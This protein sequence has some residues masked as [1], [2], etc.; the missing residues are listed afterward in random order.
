MATITESPDANGTA[1][2]IV[3]R[4][5]PFATIFEWVWKGGAAII[6]VGGGALAAYKHF[7]TEEEV[8]KL[9]CQMA[10]QNKINSAMTEASGQ[11]RS[12]LGVLKNQLVAPAN[13]DGQRRSLEAN[14]K[15]AIDG[16]D[17]ALKD[18][19]NTKAIILNGAYVGGTFKCNI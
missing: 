6:L 9:Q 16:V 1:A 17:K 4:G 13:N 19:D 12:A 18:A 11:I 14:L 5:S 3:A 2:A 10:L 8:E 7:A 15:E